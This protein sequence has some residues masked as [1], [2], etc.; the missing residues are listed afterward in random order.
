MPQRIKFPCP[1]VAAMALVTSVRA[2]DPP[3]VPRL[4]DP[5]D[6]P[7]RPGPPA[8]RRGPGAGPVLRPPD[9]RPARRRTDHARRLPEGPRQG[10]IVLK[11]SPDG[12]LHWSDRLPTPEN[13]V[14][15]KETPTIHRVVDPRGTKRLILFSGLYPIRMSVSEDD[16]QTWTPLEPIGDFGGIVAMAS[17]ERLKNG[18][19][20]ALFHDDGRFL[21]DR[22]R[23]RSS[24]STGR[25]RRTA[26]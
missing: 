25:S 23:S 10:R 18:D 15:S 26:A 22:A 13:W 24:G 7:G 4:L 11:R 9:H 16:G 5:A 19:S 21:R 20:M 3:P 8:N 14:T 6:R 12:G 2:D 17:V 1:I